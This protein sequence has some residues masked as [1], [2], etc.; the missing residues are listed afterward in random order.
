MMTTE[1]VN[2]TAPTNKHDYEESKHDHAK[3][4]QDHRASKQDNAKK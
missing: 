1:N 4:K 2:K 3:T